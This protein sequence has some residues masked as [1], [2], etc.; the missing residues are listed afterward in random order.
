MTKAIE[1][2]WIMKETV[3]AIHDR[4]IDEHGGTM[5]VRD[6]GLLESALARPRNLAAYTTPKIHELAAAYAWGVIKD[7]PFI[8]GNKRTANV[9]SIGNPPE[10]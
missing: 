10:N 5:G 7:H 6:M 4:Q 3:L 2:R 9:I 8:D 1:W